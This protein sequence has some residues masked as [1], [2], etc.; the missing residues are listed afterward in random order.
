MVKENGRA[1]AKTG[2]TV[3]SRAKPAPGRGRIVIWSV[4]FP[5]TNADGLDSLTA[6]LTADVLL[7][8]HGGVVVSATPAHPIDYQS[9]AIRRGSLVE[10]RYESSESATSDDDPA[11][12][13]ELVDAAD[14]A[15]GNPEIE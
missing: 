1:E 2:K 3:G 15:T 7:D 6:K 5:A 14:S 13:F 8:D 12:V 4:H 9:G 11:M 10:V